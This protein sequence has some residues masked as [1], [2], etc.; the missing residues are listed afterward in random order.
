MSSCGD[1]LIQYEEKHHEKLVEKFIEKNA[2]KYDEFVL[3]EMIDE[4]ADY[5]DYLYDQE[6]DEDIDL[7][8]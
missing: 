1:E 6:R 5:S 4:Q 8:D 7:G 2:D 3:A